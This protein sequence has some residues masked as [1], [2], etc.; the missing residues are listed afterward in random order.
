MNR[1][2]LGQPTRQ[3]P[4]GLPYPDDTTYRHIRTNVDNFPHGFRTEREI[5][6]RRQKRRQFLDLISA[7]EDGCWIWEGTMN[8]TRG[9][10]VFWAKYRRFTGSGW[11]ETAPISGHPFLWLMLEWFPNE[12]LKLER[13]G[14]GTIRGHNRRTV[15][16]CGKLRC[17]RPQCRRSGRRAPVPAPRTGQHG[18]PGGAK[19]TFTPDQV[20]LI[21]KRRQN[22]EKLSEI[23]A[24]L[25]RPRETVSAVAR[26]RAYA[27]VTEAPE[28]SLEPFTEVHGTMGGRFQE[29]DAERGS[30]G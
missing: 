4:P 19:R 23:A 18:H 7:D 27:W 26:G 12:I 3:R 13:A 14:N 28:G 30:D 29:I 9:V 10:P 8:S 25:G 24:D 22:G 11:I 6:Q 2:G 5:Y 1:R 20:R 15:A 17:I 21:R 16:I